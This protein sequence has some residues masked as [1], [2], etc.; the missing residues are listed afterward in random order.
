MTSADLNPEQAQALA[1]A[2]ARQLRY[3]NRLCSRMQRLRW[4]ADERMC[5]LATE[6]RNAVQKLHTAAASIG[7][8]RVG[9]AKRRG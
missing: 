2:L 6:A 3:L 8:V 1:R 4:A 5:V 7:K 9:E